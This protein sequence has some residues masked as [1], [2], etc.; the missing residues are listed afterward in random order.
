M[1]V[2]DRLFVASRKDCDLDAKGKLIDVRWKP[3]DSA[4]CWR[5]NAGVFGIDFT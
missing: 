2:G 5:L 1:A 3:G 4:P